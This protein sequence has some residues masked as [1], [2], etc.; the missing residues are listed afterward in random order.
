MLKIILVSFVDSSNIGDQLLS[1]T[2][3]E[4]LFREH[5]THKYSYK[6]VPIEELSNDHQ[7]H[8]RGLLKKIYT[9][10]FRKNPVIYKFVTKRNWEKGVKKMQENP[11]IPAFKA[12]LK[13]ADL[14]VFGGGNAIFD[15]SPYIMSATRFD[16][17]VD[18]AKETQTKIFVSS[19][20]IGPFM[21]EEQLVKTMKTLEKCDYVT[22]RDQK[23]QNYCEAYGLTHTHA[24]I[25]SVFL[26]PEV[27]PY[28]KLAR[29]QKRVGHQVGICVIDYRINGV[30]IEE[31]Q[32][33]KTNM[34]ALVEQLADSGKE[35]FLFS[36]ELQDYETVAEI[37]EALPDKKHVTVR[38]ING[39]DDLLALYTE[40]DLIIGTRMHS[41]IIAVSQFLPIVGLS[42]QQKVDE[43]FK[44][45]GMLES[46]F[47]LKD[48]GEELPEVL[49]CVNRKLT[50]VALETEKL[51]QVKKDLAEKFAINQEIMNEI[52][53]DLGKE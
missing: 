51:Y 42:W 27:I 49:A 22:F 11:N 12:A 48:L 47:A 32:K 37:Y 3:E 50:S 10:F 21:T 36:S 28:Q 17:I 39:V 35:V 38:E 52:T 2:L 20:G 19:I 29:A 34:E 15:L 46:L 13:G 18:L 1:T 43:M 8:K 45:I 9:R 24:S 33:Y 44:N 4:N 5:E 41:M 25:D 53:K 26:L 30:S 31:Y 40:L 16:L 6:L 14:L 7:L 23:S